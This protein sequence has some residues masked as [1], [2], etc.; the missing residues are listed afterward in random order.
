[1]N[2]VLVAVGAVIIVLCSGVVLV[3]TPYF[4]ILRQT[5]P[6]SVPLGEADPA[7]ARGRAAYVDLGCVYCHSQQPRDKSFGPDFAR[8]WGYQPKAQDYTGQRPHQLGTMRT[9]PD[10]FNIGDRNPSLQWNL[11]H[12]YA[13]RIMVPWSIMPAYPF[14]FEEKAEPGPDDVVLVFDWIGV[15][16]EPP[17]VASQ[18]ALDLVR[19]LQSLKQKE[20]QNVQ[21]GT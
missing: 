15:E 9:G 10:L 13:P 7:I 20:E 4:S 3:V 16:T 19:Y 17:I 21:P 18:K 8:G 5:E 2:K 12:L 11:M 1:M 14:L 6:Q